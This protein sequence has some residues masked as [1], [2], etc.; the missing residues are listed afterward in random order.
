MSI[1]AGAFDDL[2]GALDAPPTDLTGQRLTPGEAAVLYDALH[3]DTTDLDDAR[4]GSDQDTAGTVLSPPAAA[5]MPAAAA[6][7]AGQRVRR[8]LRMAAVDLCGVVLSLVIGR[9]VLQG[10]DPTAV[11]RHIGLGYVIAAPAFLLAFALHG[12]YRDR[13]Q[14]LQPSAASAFRSMAQAFASSVLLLLALDAT[15]N[16]SADRD[17]QVTEACAILAPTLITVPMLRLLAVRT[18]LRHHRSQPR[19][20]ILGSGRVALSLAQRLKRS[21]GVTLVGLVDDGLDDPDLLG[22]L[23]S[24]PDIVEQHRVD[25]VI[26]AFSQTPHHETLLLLRAL[27]GRVGISVVPRMYELLSWRASIEELHGIPLL[28]VAPSQLSFTARAAKRALDLAIAGGL[29]VI[30]APVL[31]AIAVAIRCTSPGPALFRQERVGRNGR[32]FQIYKFRTMVQG[33]DARKAELAAFNEMDGPIFK[34]RQDPRV[35]PLGRFLRRASIDELPQL[36]NVVRGEMSL[37]GPRPCLPEEVERISGWASTR[38]SVP[39]GITGLWQVS[40]RSELSKEDLLHLDSVY[41]SS[42]SLG[43]D[44]RILLRTP[45]CVLRREGAY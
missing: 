25:R 36:F 26:V 21:P 3:I 45:R 23:A 29:L 13:W 27:K 2:P 18:I 4:V 30:C 28:H 5:L 38:F 19:V 35:T 20:L 32:C 42:W 39:P 24:L 22:P 9:A 40:G 8:A 16:L 44:I 37:V 12:N 31:S 11:S 14:R 6:T 7:V 41:V 1:V 34:I 33:A 15:L 10:L 17:I 43:W